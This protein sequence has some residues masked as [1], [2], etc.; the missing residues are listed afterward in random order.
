VVYHNCQQPRHYAREC[1]LSSVT[2]MYFRALDHDTEYCLTLLGKIYEKRNQNNHNV[3]WISAEEM[4]DGRN[5]NIF[6]CGG[7]KRRDDAVRQ[8]PAQHQWVK[9]NVE[10]HKQFDA[11]N[12]K[13]L[14]KQ[15]KQEFSKPY[16]ASTSIA[17]HTQD[18][19]TYTMPS[20]L[21]HTN[22]AHPLDK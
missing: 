7:A 15:V 19:A 3:Q 16:I 5:I 8:D 14:F 12:K 10:P 13:E 21:D 18:V 6:T 9:K 11:Q 4:D 20:S 22:E 1:P 2:C 17:H